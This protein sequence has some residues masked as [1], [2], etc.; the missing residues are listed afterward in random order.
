MSR[1]IDQVCPIKHDTLIQCW[2]NVGPTSW[3]LALL[4]TNIGSTFR[5]CRGVAEVAMFVICCLGRFLLL[6]APGGAPDAL[7]ISTVQNQK[8]IT[9]H[10]SSEQLPPFCVAL[11]M[12]CT[13][14]SV[15]ILVWN[16]KI[17]AHLQGVVKNRW[18]GEVCSTI[19][20]CSV[21]YRLLLGWRGPIWAPRWTGG[22]G[23][24]RGP[25]RHG[26][27]TH[28]W[29][30]VLLHGHGSQ[31]GRAQLDVGHGHRGHW[32]HTTQYD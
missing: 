14:E 2:I 22:H 11:L 27:L 17:H 12:I 31:P 4:W 16:S 7:L 25:A 13:A 15:R 23:R 8:A 28:T 10:F 19:V 6:A 30:I 9:A 1:G 21:G 5:A 3:T 29:L 20:R 18:R 32:K 24:S 26:S